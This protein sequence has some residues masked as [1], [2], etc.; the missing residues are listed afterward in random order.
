MVYQPVRT[1]IIGNQTRIVTGA[2]IHRITLQEYGSISTFADILSIFVQIRSLQARG[3]CNTDMVVT[4]CSITTVS[5]RP[6]EIVIPVS[7]MQNRSEEHTSEL[8][9]G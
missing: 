3:S 2:G 9:S 1:L 5:S 8:Q 6:K 4:S 7:L